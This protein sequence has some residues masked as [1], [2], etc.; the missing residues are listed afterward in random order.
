MRRRTERLL[1]T[2]DAKRN[3][4]LYGYS[5]LLR[6]LLQKSAKLGRF[7]I[8]PGTSCCDTQWGWQEIYTHSKSC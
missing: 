8:D 6:L 4:Y 1:L 7:V 2:S 3:V 5:R